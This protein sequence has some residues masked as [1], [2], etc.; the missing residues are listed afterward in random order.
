M[1]GLMHIK[2]AKGMSCKN[3][4]YG[5]CVIPEASECREMRMCVLR[6]ITIHKIT[7]QSQNKKNSFGRTPMFLFK[8]IIFLLNI[9]TNRTCNLRKSEFKIFFKVY[10]SDASK[11]NN[12][13]ILHALWRSFILQIL[14]NTCT[15]NKIF[16]VKSY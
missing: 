16:F 13:N 11:W 3:T 6:I 8:L 5:V 7:R 10:C 15:L 2:N 12:T 1:I 14:E 4:T 9:I